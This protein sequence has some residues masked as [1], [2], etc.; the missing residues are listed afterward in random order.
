MINT[1]SIL[2][3]LKQAKNTI[4]SLRKERDYLKN[5]LLTQANSEEKLKKEIKNLNSENKILRKKVFAYQENFSKKECITKLNELFKEN[6]SNI[7][8][9]KLNL[10]LELKD[11]I[12]K[13]LNDEQLTHVIIKLYDIIDTINQNL[14][15]FAIDNITNKTKNELFHNKDPINAD[16]SP[17]KAQSLK[18]N[19]AELFNESSLIFE[20]LDEQNLKISKISNQMKQIMSKSCF[21][22]SSNSMTD[23]K[24]IESRY[25]SYK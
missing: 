24:L 9:K 3:D 16:I 20:T 22:R 12:I 19:I 11:H 18:S 4:F 6:F 14:E 5:E 7:K 15:R 1:E 25:Q 8:L 21:R 10:P 2:H 17:D 23:L 13:L